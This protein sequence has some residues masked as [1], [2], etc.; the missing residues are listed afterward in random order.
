[1]VEVFRDDDVG[2]ER[3][4]DANPRGYVINT[5][6]SPASD[7]LKLHQAGCHHISVLQ[8]GATTWTSGGYIK[9]CGPDIGQL[10]RWAVREVGA[11]VD[12]GCG[13]T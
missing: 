2:Y 5:R 12:R 1:M 10:E 11:G 6:R 13:C 9:V 4:L 3:W 7:Y 8:A